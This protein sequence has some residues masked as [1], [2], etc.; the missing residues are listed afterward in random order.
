MA[1]R[2]RLSDMNE[3]DGYAL[4]ERVLRAVAHTR[5]K[6][7]TTELLGVKR[8]VSQATFNRAYIYNGEDRVSPTSLRKIERLLDLPRFVLDEVLRGD[9]DAVAAREFADNPEARNPMLDAMW[10]QP[11]DSGNNHANVR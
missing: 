6:S 7:P 2:S 5:M 11:N 8:E 9:R 4:L 1:P 10:Q 3:P